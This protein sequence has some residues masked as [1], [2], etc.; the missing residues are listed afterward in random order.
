MARISSDGHPGFVSVIET[1]R[2]GLFFLVDV[3][4]CLST[5]KIDLNHNLLL[6]NILFELNNIFINNRLSMNKV[7]FLKITQ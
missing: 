5:G 6:K 2:N 3:F 7:T 4:G 1:A